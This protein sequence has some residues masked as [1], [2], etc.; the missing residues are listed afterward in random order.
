MR[1]PLHGRR[2]KSDRQIKGDDAVKRNFKRNWAIFLALGLAL[3]ALTLAVYAPSAKPKPPAEPAT[4]MPETPGYL[5]AVE[6][7]PDTVDFQ[8]TT[9]HYTVAQN[10]FNRLV[11]LENGGEGSVVILPSRRWNV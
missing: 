5:V 8:C 2:R 3:L 6:D 10:V 9:I 1:T 4:V 11:E 7:E